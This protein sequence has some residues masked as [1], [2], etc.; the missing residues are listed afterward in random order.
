MQTGESAVS[1]QYSEVPDLVLQHNHTPFS[2]LLYFFLPT[3]INLTK[4]T[5]LSLHRRPLARQLR[6]QTQ[7]VFTCTQ[8]SQPAKAGLESGWAIT[9]RG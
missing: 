3:K 7:L 1:I 9:T 8:Q 2:P 4:L 6:L 5:K